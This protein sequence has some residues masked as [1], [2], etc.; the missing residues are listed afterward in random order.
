[1]IKQIYVSISRIKIFTLK[2]KYENLTFVE[3][4]QYLPAGVSWVLLGFVGD[5]FPGGDGDVI[6][7]ILLGRRGALAAMTE[8]EY[9]KHFDENIRKANSEQ[10]NFVEMII[11]AAKVRALERVKEIRYPDSDLQRLH[12]LTGE[13]GVGKTFVYNV[14]YYRLFLI[15]FILFS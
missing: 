9:K 11:N 1:M 12:F 3:L 7:A 2:L 8:G 4:G 14:I 10:K 13:G 5:R 6:P 15:E